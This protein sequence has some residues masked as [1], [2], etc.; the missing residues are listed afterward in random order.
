MRLISCYVENFGG[1]SRFSLDF[2]E[3]LTVI[4]APN[5]FGKTTLA[6]FLRAMLYGFPRK[7]GKGLSRREK[8]TPWNGGVCRGH[9]TFEHEG[10]R[11]RLERSFGDR[12]QQDT[13]RLVELDTGK[14]S[15]RFSRDIGLEL[16]GLDAD[17]F[18]RSTYLPQNRDAAPMATDSIRAKLSGLVE[19]PADVGSFEKAMKALQEKR[20]L[21]VHDKGQ[22]G[23]V[24][25]AS[26]EITRLQ[27]A[28]EAAR[29]DGAR[30]PAVTEKI[31]ALEAA[32]ERD[33]AQLEQVRRALEDA[34]RRHLRQQA[35][36]LAAAKAELAALEEK[37]PRGIPDGSALELAAEAADLSARLGPASESERA[38]AILE[39]NDARFAD[40][41][42]TDGD[43]EEM[44]RCWDRRR[45]LAARIA[46]AEKKPKPRQ[47][48]LLA[49]LAA[50]ALGAGL[51][52]LLRQL[53]IPAAAAWAAAA[54]AGA[55]AWKTGRTGREPE[56]LPALEKQL[57]RCD[58][59]LAEF[60][61][62]FAMTPGDDPGRSLDRLRRLRDDW[63]RASAR[64]EGEQ[65]LDRLRGALYEKTGLTVPDRGA[66]LSL[67][68]DIRAAREL[69]QTIRTLEAR[70][71][72]CGPIPEAAEDD[73]P[74]PETLRRRE[75]ALLAARERSAAELPALRQEAARLRDAAA[76]AVELEAEIA[77][78]QARRDADREKA[79]LLKDT[80]AFLEKA[81]E[82][83]S[84]AYMG[85]IR[86]RFAGLMEQ[87]AD[88]TGER[89]LVTESM[90][91]RL[92]QA[93]AGRELA[94]FS[95]GQTDLVLL[96]MRLALVDALFRE[97]KPFVI[98][99]DPFVNLDDG[100]LARA[101]ALL[102][103]LG[104]E[105]QIV[106]LTCSLSRVPVSEK[107]KMVKE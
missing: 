42:P 34:G 95:A 62:A 49:A 100:A 66:L 76:E 96:C 81:R 103:E 89:L 3:G 35:A 2:Q 93:G 104:R 30:L 88:V 46:G 14:V 65:T 37:Y 74:E 38:A 29:A 107:S 44:E 25:A 31:T 28:L 36:D 21:Y 45:S 1:L 75:R 97:A 90:Q 80:A 20:R 17:S 50:L 58:G 6:E 57:A 51:W 64:R 61:A 7:S 15:R 52:L 56:E 5:G 23:S 83:L 94:W 106:Y 63:S 4:H 9:L 40:G 98:L 11:Y 10:V 8:F 26:D 87:M 79:R 39:E 33:A 48:S 73:G 70:L 24:Q 86:S 91:V 47:L 102:E 78:W 99:D 82:N 43:L 22:G 72:G 13:F 68:A 16:F 92:E 67:G 41:V 85:P 55:A 84:T 105:R 53:P 27:Q 60:F 54:A 71:E 12:P 101:L 69:A 77:R 32:R 19:D 18:E 59:I